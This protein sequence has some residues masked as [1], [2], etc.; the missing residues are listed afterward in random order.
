MTIGW[1][2][3]IRLLT[4][5]QLG[6]R[7]HPQTAL[8]DNWIIQVNYIFYSSLQSFFNVP[9]HIC[10]WSLDADDFPRKITPQIVW[11]S[12]NP[13]KCTH[14]HHISTHHPCVPLKCICKQKNGALHCL[15][16][17]C[18]SDNRQPALSGW[19]TC[20]INNA[21]LDK[22]CIRNSVQ[23]SL[24]LWHSGFWEEDKEEK[25]RGEKYNLCSV[26]FPG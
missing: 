21:C 9:A 1:Y 8:T 22:E 15:Q 4:G 5:C 11:T 26:Y 13:V 17:R 25:E 12:A 18:A 7:S 23:R 14:T 20:L 2:V 3:I 6:Y 24:W 10:N 16:A 19:Y